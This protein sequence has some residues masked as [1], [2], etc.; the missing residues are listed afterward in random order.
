MPIFLILALLIAVVAV[1]F[2]LQNV[3]AIT[4]TFFIWH[5]QTSAAVALLVALAAGIV[6]TLLV[7][8]P[9]RVRGSMNNSAQKKK[10]LG[11]E[12]E[13]DAL[14]VKVDEA[15]AQRDANLKRAEAAEKEVAHLEEQLAS[16]SAAL[17]QKDEKTS[18]VDT[19]PTIP[20]VDTTPT[21][22]SS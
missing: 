16:I 4:V 17:Q 10:F 14:K 7:S 12:A 2:A 8:V 9:G 19:Q 3:A 5:I 18:V 6:I 1:I 13:R 22:P 11:L 21:Q 20:P 15:Q